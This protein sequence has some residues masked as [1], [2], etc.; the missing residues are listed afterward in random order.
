MN[1]LDDLI[2]LIGV[3][4]QKDF[5]P[6]LDV[7]AINASNVVC[8]CPFM[9]DYSAKFPESEAEV[10]TVD[11]RYLSKTPFGGVK[12][13]LLPWFIRSLFPLFTLPSLDPTNA[14]Y[15]T[16]VARPEPF[17]PCSVQWVVELQLGEGIY[18]C[19]AT[20]RVDTADTGE[21]LW[22]PVE[23]VRYAVAI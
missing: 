7:F 16:A 15:I 12:P 22:A 11:G 5:A 21:C 3:C 9:T 1:I 4:F 17:V 14:F 6:T 13:E 10:A 20:G 18:Y 23:V 19:G 8:A 2:Q